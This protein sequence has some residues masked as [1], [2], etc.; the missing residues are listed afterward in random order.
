MWVWGP[1]PRFFC[2]RERY[3]NW[4]AHIAYCDLDKKEK[5]KLI[6]QYFEDTF[7]FFFIRYSGSYNA[8]ATTHFSNC[9][10]WKCVCKKTSFWRAHGYFENKLQNL[11]IKI[12]NCNRSKTKQFF[13]LLLKILKVNTG[14]IPVL[15][16]WKWNFKKIQLC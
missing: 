12:N 8:E 5:E 4:C 6:K 16:V 2:Q 10:Y 13:L 7:I 1:V 9:Y 14:S 11:N 15:N 3:D